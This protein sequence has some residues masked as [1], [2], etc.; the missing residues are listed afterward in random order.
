MI[1]AVMLNRARG[2][3]QTWIYF[4]EK[5]S[6]SGGYTSRSNWSAAMAPLGRDAAL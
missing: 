5:T 3:D 2:T 1:V 4:S 6:P